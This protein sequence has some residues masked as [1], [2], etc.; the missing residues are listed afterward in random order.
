ML[1][2]PSVNA[3][4]YDVDVKVTN[5]KNLY[6]LKLTLINISD[7]DYGVG[8]CFMNISLSGNNSINGNVRTLN[9]WSMLSGTGY[10][11]D[12]GSPA[13]KNTDFAIIPIKVN[14]NGVVTLSNFYCSDGKED[15]FVENKII[16]LKFDSSLEN[17]GNNDDAD[18]VILD[19]NCDLSNIILN[20]GN[21]EFDSNVTDYEIEVDNI[22]SLVVDVVLSSDSAKYDVKKNKD[23]VVINVTAEDG[24]EKTYIIY[25][26]NSEK[27][28]NNVNN[29]NNVNKNQIYVPIFIGIMCVLVLI[30]I[31]RVVNNMRKKG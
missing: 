7:T 16:N 28:V 25:V 15:V 10:V 8:S 22:N 18:D 30:N 12:T 9:G 3:L 27:D 11:F 21:I 13:L 6:E 31:V 20:K 4:K 26:K 23:N 24:S 1:F 14:S 19:S 17:Q 29:V 5:K 2:I